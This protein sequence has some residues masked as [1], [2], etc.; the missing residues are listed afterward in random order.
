MGFCRYRAATS[1]DDLRL[2]AASITDTIQYHAALKTPSTGGWWYRDPM[3]WIVVL[4]IIGI[5]VL[6]ARQNK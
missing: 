1:F 6:K 3:F 5:V 2:V 4:L